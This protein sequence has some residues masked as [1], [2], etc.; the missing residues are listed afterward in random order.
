MSGASSPAENQPS[1]LTASD[2]VPPAATE[3][4]DALLTASDIVP[5]A[6]TEPVD[7]AALSDVPGTYS[8]LHRDRVHA[9]MCVS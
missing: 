2:I 1:L 4:V 9:D 7:A 5:P 8:R 3:P 6:A